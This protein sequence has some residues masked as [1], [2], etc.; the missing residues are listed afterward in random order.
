MAP[1]STAHRKNQWKTGAESKTGIYRGEI[2]RLARKL[3]FSLRAI[4]TM[5]RVMAPPK[6]P[7]ESVH[8]QDERQIKPIAEAV[9]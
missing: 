4:D 1:G 5:Q 8:K 2:D 3:I 7:N 9:T 6:A